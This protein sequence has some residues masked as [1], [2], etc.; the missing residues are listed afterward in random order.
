V[1]IDWGTSYRTLSLASL[2]LQKNQ[3]A[4]IG[5]NIDRNMKVGTR[6]TAGNGCALS[7]LET[8]TG[9]KPEIM[10]KPSTRA[11]DIIKKEHDL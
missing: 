5:C 1:G 8:A 10:G 3:A 9:I 11:F 2:Y 6:F 7:F 4:F